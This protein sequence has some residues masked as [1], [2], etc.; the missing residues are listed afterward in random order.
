MTGT[1]ITIRAVHANSKVIF[2]VHNLGPAIPMA[3]RECIFDHY[4]FPASLADRTSRTGF[5]LSVAKRIASVHGGSVWL[6]SDEAEG[7]EFFAAIPSPMQT[8]R[9]L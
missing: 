4:S 1:A 2:S 3:D 7:T 8:R 6:T 9:P 5:G